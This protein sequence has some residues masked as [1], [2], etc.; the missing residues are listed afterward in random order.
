MGISVSR[1]T[2]LVDNE[3]LQKFVG[4]AHIPVTD[5]AFWTNFLQFHIA[6][7]NN[8]SV[9]F[10]DINTHLLMCFFVYLILLIE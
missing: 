10:L 6:L 9:E 2:D 1:Q 3:Y 8:R 7:P 5:D 4:K